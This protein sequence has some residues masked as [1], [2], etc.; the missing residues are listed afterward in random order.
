[1]NEI[2]K[3]IKAYDRLQSDIDA[4]RDDIINI[5]A[6]DFDMELF[7]EDGTDDRIYYDYYFANKVIL[8]IIVNI[9]VEIPFL[10]FFRI[11]VFD[12]EK[13]IT[14]DYMTSHN[15]KDWDPSTLFENKTDSNEYFTSHKDDK[16]L[17]CVAS[18][19]IDI[20][21]IDSTDVTN[22]EIKEL[23]SCLINDKCEEMND[24]YKEFPPGKLRFV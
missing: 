14:K 18:P 24:K 21:S 2:A 17:E 22:S 6:S 13:N 16:E 4:M 5:V 7:D 11:N 15:Y 8:Y 19:K 12:T 10:Q 9:A 1:M 23:V 20:M 3:L